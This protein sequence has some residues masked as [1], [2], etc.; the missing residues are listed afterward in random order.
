MLRCFI[1]NISW[2]YLKPRDGRTDDVIMILSK[3]LFFIIVISITLSACHIFDDPEERVVIIVGK[4][5][6]TEEELRRD[7]K[8][9]TFEM[10]ITDQRVKHLIPALTERI[11]DNYLIL[12]YGKINGI[13]VSENELKQGPGVRGPQ[14]ATGNE[15]LDVRCARVEALDGDLRS[16]I[17]VYGQLS[18]VTG[19]HVH[20]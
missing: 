4:R 15:F 3:V 13:T 17:F 18:A 11:I 10:G 12:E 19:G 6:V 9:L 2:S 1:L 7:I 5:N 8:H 16:R 14:R 20:K